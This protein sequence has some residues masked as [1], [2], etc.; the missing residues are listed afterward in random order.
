VWSAWA[1]LLASAAFAAELKSAAA[2]Q[3][4]GAQRLRGFAEA[5]EVFARA[6]T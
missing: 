2:L 3:P 6:A 1:S 5:Q 4:I